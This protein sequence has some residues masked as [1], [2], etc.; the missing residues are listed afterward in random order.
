[1]LGRIFTATAIGCGIL[2]I[3]LYFL[4]A[5]SRSPSPSEDPRNIQ[6]PPWSSPASVPAPADSET[7]VQA[8]A[9]VAPAPR[10]EPAET[11]GGRDARRDA[12]VQGIAGARREGVESGGK[13]ESDAVAGGV[14]H[15]GAAG[16]R[17]A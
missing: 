14:E 8:P 16:A 3:G 6:I 15:E 17:R 11:D 9:R 7:Q 12:A 5:K 2:V 4:T 10:R 1:M 13:R